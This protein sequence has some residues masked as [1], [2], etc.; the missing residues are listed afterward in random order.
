[1]NAACM[2]DKI[3]IALVDKALDATVLSPVAVEARLDAVV[4]AST[5]VE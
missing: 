5:A 4:L 1:M 2:L 3:A